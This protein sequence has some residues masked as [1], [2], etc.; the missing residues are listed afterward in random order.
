[1]KDK[2]FI[3]ST[4]GMI[5]ISIA[6]PTQPTIEGIAS[7]LRAC[8]PVVADDAYAY[9]TVRSGNN[10]GGDLNGLCVYD[11][12][13][14]ML[15]LNQVFQ[16]NMSSPQGLALYNS[17]LYVCDGNTGLVVFDVHNG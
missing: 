2:L 6:D 14:G 7:H 11:V 13:G 9:V 1:W 12:T 8:D 4:A 17:Y 3:G 16:G 5:V 10:C 15:S